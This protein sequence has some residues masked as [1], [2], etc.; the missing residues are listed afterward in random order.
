[1]KFKNG[2][3]D[4]GY[5]AGWNL[6]GLFPEVVNR[7]TFKFIADAVWRLNTIGTQQL[8]LNLSRALNVPA[9]SAPI[10][11]LA[12]TNLRNYFRYYGEVFLLPRWSEKKINEKV[13]IRNLAP[14]LTQV[15]N[16]GIVLALPHCGNWDLAGA[17]AAKEFG[18][19]GTVAERLRPE[20]V[21]QKF[22]KMR[23]EKGLTVH[24]LTGAGS[25]YEFLK[26]CLN[27]G[28]SIA[29]LG[30]RDISGSGML[31]DFFGQKAKLPIGPA[32]L[33]LDTKKPLFSC[34]TWYEGEKLVIQFD[35]AIKIP[36]H[37]DNS[38]D[39]IKVAQQLTKEL[40][41]RFESHIK[42]HPESW[43]QLQPIWPD[44]RVKS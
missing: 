4:F 44:L 33:A 8:A 34:A 40:A 18:A 16:G 1:M 7:K 2:L 27:S 11:E 41:Q 19:L 14:V 3:V 26:D 5:W 42:V 20:G 10:R 9:D 38:R 37:P 28:M 22:L 17:W 15:R 32:M 25:P 12:R 13:E 36:S 30:D 6:F 39:L 31:V 24:P 43:H 21:F 35:E 29:L 23:Q